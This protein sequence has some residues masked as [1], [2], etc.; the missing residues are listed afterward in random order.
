MFGKKK[1]EETVS[2]EKASL[3]DVSSF[4]ESSIDKTLS[5]PKKVEEIKEEYN[6]KPK[7]DL[8]SDETIEMQVIRKLTGGYFKKKKEAR[9][10]ERQLKRAS[11]ERFH[12]SVKLGLSTEM[13]DHRIQDG[14]TNTTPKTYT[15]SIWKIILKNF[16]TYFN[17]LMLALAI[18]LILVHSSLANFFFAA[19]AIFNL[20][21]GTVQEIRAKQVTDKMSL[22]V[23]PKCTVIRNGTEEDVKE[24]DIVLDDI[25]V[26]SSGKQVSADCIVKEGAVEANESMQTGES[27]PIKKKVGDK[28]LA[29]SFIVSGTAYAQVEAVGEDSF[30][31]SIQKTAKTYK[32]VTSP[33]NHTINALIQ[34]ISFLVLPL[35]GL[36]FYVN[37]QIGSQ[38]GNFATI[39]EL[40]NFSVEKTASSM[41]GMIPSGLVLLTSVA[42][43]VGVI[44]LS[45]RKV[46]VQ[47]LY[48]IERLARVNCVCFDKTGTLTDGTLK[49][50]KTIKAD[51]K[52]DLDKTL[53]SYLSCFKETNQTS[54]ALLKEFTPNS[55][56]T[57][58]VVLPFSSS[59][60]M[61]AVSFADGESYALGAPEYLLD[62]SKS[63]TLINQ[64]KEAQNN[65]FRSIA[66]CQ[67]GGIKN[68]K[69]VGKITPKAIFIISDHIREEASDTVKW[70]KESQVEIK[71]ISGDSPITVS[72][73]AKKVGIDG[74]EKYV[75]L[76]GLSL[77]ET[78]RI[79]SEYTVFGRVSP[80]Q[81]A[82]LIQELKSQ[83]KK[84]AM[85]GDGVNDILAMKQADCSVAMASGADATRSAAHVILLDSNFS[86][87]PGIVNE[88]RRVVNNIQ[89]SASLFTMKTFFTILLSLFVDICFFCKLGMSYP[90]SPKN[91]AVMEFLPIGMC[92]F[93][94]ALQPNNKPIGENFGK[95]IIIDALPGALA[96]F[97]GVATC[98]LLQNN[99]IL[100]DRSSVLSLEILAINTAAFL[101]LLKIC[102]PFN[103]FRGILFGVSVAGAIGL[104]YGFSSRSF[105]VDFNLL[106]QAYWLTYLYISLGMA[107]II[108]A[109][110]LIIKQIEKSKF[111]LAKRRQDE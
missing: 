105:G 109:S 11:I 29:G 25:I 42:L 78:K 72:N 83:G 53:G 3:E 87:M 17:V 46:L 1:K 54:L 10:R 92:A 55:V 89:L 86:S 39:H 36:M 103:L 84:V 104:L 74:A 15:N 70:F 79:A 82:A 40:F 95:K 31:G 2:T 28:L 41:I 108:F 7:I 52:F 48:S 96:M 85:T 65:G 35:G 73:I 38:R 6:K 90:F 69:V 59:R 94:L 100:T 93:F 98:M 22:I 63:S 9:E 19:I 37:Y 66:F 16:F 21:I 18:I 110:G 77:G 111:F 4:N 12:P 64:I 14:M 75:S 51:D 76:E 13:V 67:V 62:F 88:G 50:E 99:G 49:L 27:K 68:D 81:K 8:A 71:V 43:T 24:A 97:G 47:D 26:V 80:E 58:E 23:S 33:L 107:A 32:K 30:S 5:D 106:T 20:I 44:R 102:L 34:I 45:K 101:I 60:K 61:S 57:P 56:L 91:L